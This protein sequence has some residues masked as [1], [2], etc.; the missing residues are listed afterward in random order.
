[1]AYAGV[2]VGVDKMNAMGYRGF[3]YRWDEL[4]RQKVNHHVIVPVH[5][6]LKLRWVCSVCFLNAALI[7]AQGLQ[8]LLNCRRAIIDNRDV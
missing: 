6:A 7:A 8:I 3:R 2:V 1:M 5:H 4:A